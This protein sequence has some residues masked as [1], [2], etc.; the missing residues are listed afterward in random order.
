MPSRANRNFPPPTG[1][2]LDAEVSGQLN[3]AWAKSLTE[4]RNSVGVQFKKLQA[5]LADARKQV[6]AKNE[7]KRAEDRQKND[8]D[9]QDC[10]E[11][12]RTAQLELA[13]IQNDKDNSPVLG[14]FGVLQ[15]ER[16]DLQR[17]RPSPPRQGGNKDYDKNE[18]AR[19]KQD[20]DAKLDK[21][22]RQLNA[23]E[24]RLNALYPQVQKIQTQLAPFLAILREQEPLL[25][26]LTKQQKH[27]AL[28]VM[29]N[30]DATQAL[31]IAAKSFTT[32]GG[33]N[34]EQEK[35]RILESYKTK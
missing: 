10:N 20:Y 11:K 16:N 29:E 25:Q 13:R 32:Y 23:I 14:E 19:E 34:L 4:G 2:L 31:D 9:L 12:M 8:T 6:K 30:D 5:D 1:K 17:N 24:S 21:M 3:G 22:D 33:I 18:E 15:N 7:A 28:P 27:L 35:K 26:T